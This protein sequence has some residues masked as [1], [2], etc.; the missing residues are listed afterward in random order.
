MSLRLLLIFTVVFGGAAVI[1]SQFIVR[2]HIQVLASART[3]AVM[4][5][6]R[7]RSVHEKTN[8]ALKESQTKLA[9]TE[10]RLKEATTQ[11]AAAN[12]KAGEQ[13]QRAKLLDQELAGT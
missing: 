1:V 4:D 13:E 8:T 7:E 2:P 12:T 3:K 5:Y 10:K 9:A 11:L 6:E